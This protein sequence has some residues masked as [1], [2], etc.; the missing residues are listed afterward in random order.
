MFVEGY[1]RIYEYYK[2][3]STASPTRYERRYYFQQDQREAFRLALIFT[4]FDS[5]F[6]EVVSLPVFSKA[7]FVIVLKFLKRTVL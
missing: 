7:K 2:A 3:Y 6:E 5:K 1:S 4:Y